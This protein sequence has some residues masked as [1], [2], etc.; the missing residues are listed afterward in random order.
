MIRVIN[1]PGF[2]EN[3]TCQYIE[4]G[5]ALLLSITLEVHFTTIPSFFHAFMKPS[6]TLY[7]IAILPPEDVR[8]IIS[9]LKEYMKENY[10]A[11]HALKSPPHITLIPPFRW[12]ETDQDIIIRE[13]ERFSE[14]EKAFTV[15][16]KDYGAF[17]PRVLYINISRNRILEDLYSRF[18]LATEKW[19]TLTDK[20]I[21]AGRFSPHITLATRDLSKDNFHKAWEEFRDKSFSA[22]F[23]VDKIVLLKHN[24]KNW[25]IFHEA[26]FTENKK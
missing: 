2:N 15:T 11:A 6:K 19:L 18:V 12:P 10:K 7:F 4:N 1:R 9:G 13:I 17:P 8:N 3:I 26:P 23:V 24:G 22:D 25:D 20:V 21:R 16:L 5:P 14:K